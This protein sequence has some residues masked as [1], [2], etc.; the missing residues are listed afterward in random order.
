MKKR[1]RV[2]RGTIT[3]GTYKKIQLDNSDVSTGWIVRDFRVAASETQSYNVAIGTLTTEEPGL[4]TWAVPGNWDLS[5]SRQIGW[6][7]FANLTDVDWSGEYSLLDSTNI[8]IE[9]LYI[10]AFSRSNE[11]P[12][13]YYIEIESAKFSKSTGIMAMVQNKGQDVP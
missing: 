6:A 12:M 2:L 11:A 7:R 8:I 9:D 5:E 13:N 3:N 10:V 1:T 4:S